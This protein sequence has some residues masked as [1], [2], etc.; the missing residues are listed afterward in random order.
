MGRSGILAHSICLY[1][2]SSWFAK[3]S[4]EAVVFCLC[5]ISLQNRVA[6]S[7]R[8]AENPSPAQRNST[9]HHLHEKIEV[10]AFLVEGPQKRSLSPKEMEVRFSVRSVIHQD[11]HIADSDYAVLDL[12]QTLTTLCL[13][14]TF[15]IV[16]I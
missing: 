1:S 7:L 3:T 9:S 16:G 5:G 4:R 13:V 14:L 11:L 8:A 12:H 15:L 2:I 6:D 10:P